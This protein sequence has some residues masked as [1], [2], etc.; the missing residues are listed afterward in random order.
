MIDYTPT[1]IEL[2]DTVYNLPMNSK[3]KSDSDT[4][5]IVL[6]KNSKIISQLK[7]SSKN[8][9]IKIIGFKLTN[10]NE[11]ENLKAVN[12]LFNEAD[13]D[14]VVHN[15]LGNRTTNEQT[16]FSIY[17]KLMNRKELPTAIELAMEIET[18]MENDL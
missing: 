11:T 13:C 2:E 4:I 3:L 12:K 14:Y 16:N 7:S 5:K 15:D 1:E 9:K 6:Q 10:S 17:D 8:K 18:I